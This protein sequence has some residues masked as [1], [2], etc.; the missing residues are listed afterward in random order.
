[1]FSKIVV[2]N[3]Y[4]FPPSFHRQLPTSPIFNERDSSHSRRVGARQ[5]ISNKRP[6]TDF[7]SREDFFTLSQEK[8]NVLFNKK[9]TLHLIMEY[10][11]K[12]CKQNK[13]RETYPNVRNEKSRGKLLLTL[14]TRCQKIS[15]KNVFSDWD[16][17]L[18]AQILKFYTLARWLSQPS[19]STAQTIRK[20]RKCPKSFGQLN[21]EFEPKIRHFFRDGSRILAVSLQSGG[22]LEWHF[23]QPTIHPSGATYHSKKLNKSKKARLPPPTLT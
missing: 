11:A 1:M 13:V 8:R 3:L 22:Q 16:F 10:L 9:S 19:N 21:D 2:I 18:P 14:I 17:F 4:I 15:R 12:Q 6:P 5:R 7:V 23:P 20:G